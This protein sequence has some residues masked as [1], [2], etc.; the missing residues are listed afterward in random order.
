MNATHSQHTHRPHISE[1]CMKEQHEFWIKKTMG[2]KSRILESKLNVSLWKI[3]NQAAQTSI[4]EAKNKKEV[5][6]SFTFF[7]F[8]QTISF[9]FV[10][11]L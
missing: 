10:P 9:V 2:K 1:G 7:S 8:V 4:N 3:W 11:W 6:Y 5:P